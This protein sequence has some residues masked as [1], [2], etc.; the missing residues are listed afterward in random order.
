MLRFLTGSVQLC[1]HMHK[2]ISKFRKAQEYN[3]DAIALSS[4]P[5][6]GISTGTAHDFISGR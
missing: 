1:Q 3:D 4:I 6:A 5:F 2:K